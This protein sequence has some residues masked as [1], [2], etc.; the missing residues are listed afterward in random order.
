MVLALDHHWVW[1]SWYVRD[2]GLWHAFFLQA[3]KSLPDPEDPLTRVTAE[4]DSATAAARLADDYAR[5]IEELVR[6]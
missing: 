5:R 2:G 4:A 6:H 1:D 3:P